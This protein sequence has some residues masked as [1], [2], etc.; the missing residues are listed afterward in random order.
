MLHYCFFLWLPFPY[1]HRKTVELLWEKKCKL[2]FHPNACWHVHRM[3]AATACMVSKI[4][5][6]TNPITDINCLQAKFL[7]HIG[8]RKQAVRWLAWFSDKDVSSFCDHSCKMPIFLFEL[9][10]GPVN[11]RRLIQINVLV[12]FFFF[13]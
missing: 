6:V 4:P 12:V 13:S 3:A 5:Y 1:G 10:N 2:L 7:K 9:R 8:L 11:N